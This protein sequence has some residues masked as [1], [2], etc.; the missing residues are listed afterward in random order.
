MA[1]RKK[2]N[3]PAVPSRPSWLIW[4]III[5]AVVLG[6]LAALSFRGDAEQSTLS[7]LLNGTFTPTPTNTSTATPEPTA[8]PTPLPTA[9]HTPTPTSPAA[10]TQDSNEEST[11]AMES[12]QVW[13]YSYEV[14]NTYPH[15]PEAFTQGLIFEDG[16]FYEGTGL[17][18]GRSSLRKV[19]VETGEVLQ[20]IN[21]DNPYFGEGITT[22]GDKIYQLTWQSNIGFVYDKDSFELIKTFEYP[23][24]GWGLTHDGEKLI[25]SDGTANLYFLDPETLERI[26]QVEVTDQGMPVRLLNELE[27]INGEIF[28]NVWQTNFI[29]R[30]DPVTGT[31]LG[32]IDMSNILSPEDI[33][34][35]I[36]VLNGIAYDQAGDRLF[37]TGK[38]WPR[39]FEIRLVPQN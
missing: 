7:M 3:Q 25:M 21:L 12:D 8:T 35:P 27:Y 28:A 23:T 18:G 4:G 16:I 14:L 37:V 20:I 13:I 15:D 29:V 32:V 34:G 10:T 2:S 19:E 30:I 11:E 5:T 17:R 24:E 26:G 22:F 9:T 36:D 31:V 38:L 6:A 1:K 33:T 39:L